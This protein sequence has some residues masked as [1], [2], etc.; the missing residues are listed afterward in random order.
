MKIKDPISALT[1]FIG[2][3]LSIIAASLLVFKSIQNTTLLHVTSFTLFGA[4][5]ILLYLASTVYHSVNKPKLSAILHRIDHMMIFVLI[6]GSYTPI[7]LI[8]LQG[9]W[10]FTLITIIW[11]IAL[12]GII[13]KALW[14]N[15]PRWLST[16]IYILMGWLV[17]IAFNPLLKALPTAAFYW[18]LAGGIIY[19]LGGLIYALKWPHFKFKHFGFHELFHLFVMGGSFCHFMLMYLYILPMQI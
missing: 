13:L 14:I 5:L 1:H 4:S 16:G 11:T 19:T 7:C 3:I 17:I 6:A 2:M 8:A 10:G 15:A 12:G 18:L 9:F